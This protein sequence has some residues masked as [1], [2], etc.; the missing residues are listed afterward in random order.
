MPRSPFDAYLSGGY[1]TAL[2][3]SSIDSDTCNTPPNFGASASNHLL[4]APYLID[5]RGLLIGRPL[6]NP[7]DDVIPDLPDTGKGTHE[8]A[9]LAGA[10]GPAALP[11]TFSALGRTGSSC[12]YLFKL[13]RSCRRFDDHLDA[14]INKKRYHFSNVGKQ[15]L[16]DID[17]SF[18]HFL[19]IRDAQDIKRTIIRIILSS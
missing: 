10:V 3:E 14:R 16:H 12:L 1:H 11:A 9:G 15:A 2:P 6:S 13:G 8:W 17:G 7:H 4:V 19:R 18:G 5:A